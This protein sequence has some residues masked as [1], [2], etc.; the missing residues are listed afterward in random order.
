M[1][2][3]RLLA[4]FHLL[5]YLPLGGLPSHRYTESDFK[6]MSIEEL[7]SFRKSGWIFRLIMSLPLTFFIGTPFDQLSE[8]IGLILVAMGM[9]GL[10]FIV[11][12]RTMKMCKQELSNREDAP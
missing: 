10:V 9:A 1:V 3:G 7:K 2:R 11:T 12:H 4:I 5:T 6:E 8:Y